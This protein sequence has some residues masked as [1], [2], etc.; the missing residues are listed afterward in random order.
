MWVRLVKQSV[1]VEA[2]P[3]LKAQVSEGLK[4]ERLLILIVGAMVVIQLWFGLIGS[5]FWLDETGTWWIVK[6]GPAEAIRRAFSWSGQSPFFYLIAWSS[7]KLFGLNEVGLRAPSVLAMSAAIYFLYRIAERIFDRATAAV[8]AFVFLCASSFYAIDARP[9]ALAMLCLT[10][11][12]WALLRW[13][14]ANRPVY[15]IIY[16]IAGTGLIYAHCV[17]S[18]GLVAGV[19]YA[20]A[21]VW[22]RQRRLIVLVVMELVTALLCLPLVPELIRFYSTRS[23]HTFAALPGVARIL[24]GLTPCSWL[25]GLVL[26]VWAYMLFIGKTEAVGKCTRNA[27]LLIGVWAL[28]APLF[29]ILLPLFA[30]LRMFVARYYSSSL[31][32]Q[33]LLVGGLFASIRSWNVRRALVLTIGVSSVIAQGRI[34]T[35]SHGKEDWKNAMQFVR[36]EAGTAPVLLVSGFAE[37]SDFASLKDPKLHDIL[38]APELIYGEPPISVRLPNRLADREDDDMKRVAGQIENEPRFYLLMRNPDR[39]YEMWLKKRLDRCESAHV[40]GDFGNLSVTRFT[41]RR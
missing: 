1:E 2:I 30:D 21:M 31:P 34:R 20:A 10:L 40:G 3:E 32:G 11:S 29:L 41:C 8:V 27:A 22:N 39:S 14:D 15:A 24:N 18:L 16:V 13:L 19:I 17:M 37:A 33:A 35:V 25:G 36:S 7:S 23:S 12:V 5:S 38:F 28:F 6:D 26:L 9:Y 4:S